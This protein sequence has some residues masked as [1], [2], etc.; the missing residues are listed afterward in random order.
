MRRGQDAASSM[1]TA[2]TLI[3]LVAVIA[4]LG[5][6]AL[7]VGG[8]MLSTLIELRA[9]TAAGRIASDLRYAQRTAI[10]SGLRT[11][12]QFDAGADAYQLYIEDADQPG[13]ANRQPLAL[14]HDTSTNT[15]EL[16]TGALQHV[17]LTVVNI[18]GTDEVEFDS[19][20][21]PYQAGGL[22][23]AQI[24][25]VQVTTGA[26]VRLHPVSGFVERE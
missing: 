17:R 8:P 15:V 20:G 4:I 13:K 10:A 26:T 9:R 22:P 19:F 16:N 12:V 18:D 21:S 11:W 14:A 24:A 23:L 7:A 3:E 1:A 2:F 25:S 5:V 6:L